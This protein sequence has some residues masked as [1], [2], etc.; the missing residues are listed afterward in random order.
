MSRWL[1]VLVYILSGLLV[2]P[3]TAVAQ[4]GPVITMTAQEAVSRALR[5]N[6]SL[7]YE[8]L[9]P[10]LSPAT[11]LAATA[12]YDLSLTSNLEVSRSPGQLSSQRSGGSPVTST[13]VGGDVGLRKLISTGTTLEAALSTVGQFGAGGTKGGLDPGYQTALRLS[14]RQSLLNGISRTANLSIITSAQL[15]R[16]SA[17]KELA[18]VAELV[19]AATLKAYWDLHAA[20]SKL[21][22]QDLALK[23]TQK[24]L[25]QTE[26]L[27][28]AGRIAASEKISA[29]YAVQAQQRDRLLVSK[30]VDDARDKLA[31]LIGLVKPSSMSTPRIVTRIGKRPT[32]WHVTRKDLQDLA[33]KN[34]GDYLSLIQQLKRYRSELKAARHRQL[35][36]LDLL[37]ELSLSGLSGTSTDGTSEYE[38]GYWSSF[39]MGRVGW[40]AGLIFSYPLSN[41]KAR[42]EAELADLKLRRIKVAMDQANQALSQELNVVW[43][44]VEVA[45][46]GFALTKAATAAAEQ[47]LINAEALFKAGKV[48]AHILS[49]VQAEVFKERLAKEQALADL[50]SARVDMFAAA[51]IL[52]QRLDQLQ[53]RR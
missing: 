29:L 2:S 52:I 46:R 48:T 7:K 5:F 24:T 53:R 41:S 13:G 8:R 47:K 22:I 30:S 28:R 38:G 18:R 12:L 19:G 1:I 23:M 35:P 21:A 44:A 10:A 39:E 51:G 43:R 26:E 32:P 33:P 37:T 25:A 49:T 14:V 40:S 9:A 20:R 45:R 31:R 50:I 16:L 11:E 34:R 6:L 3:S 4:T 27:I 17:A 36:K 15:A 42:A